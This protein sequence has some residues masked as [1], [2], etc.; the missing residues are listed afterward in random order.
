MSISTFVLSPPGNAQNTITRFVQS[1][2]PGDIEAGIAAA[3][4]EIV[5]LNTTI[6]PP[7]EKYGIAAVDIAGGGDGHTFVVQ[8]TFTTNQANFLYGVVLGASTPSFIL[9]TVHAGAY[10]ASDKDSLAIAQQVTY[11][12]MRAFD[13][14]QGKQFTVIANSFAGAAKGT[15]F[16]GLV[17]G[18]EGTP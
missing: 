13:P 11:D 2:E 15:R 4:A 6:T 10:L 16:M 8:I 9:P 12:R 1:S 17:V 18:F 5:A 7:D 3:V 14:G